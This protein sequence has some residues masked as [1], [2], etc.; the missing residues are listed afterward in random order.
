MEKDKGI[1]K[2]TKIISMSKATKKKISKVADEINGKNLFTEKIELAK[3]TL[4]NLKS[5][6]I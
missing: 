2:T 1:E 6:P 3:K 4:Q 5:L